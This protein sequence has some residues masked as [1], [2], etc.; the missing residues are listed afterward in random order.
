MQ[1]H[2]LFATAE[3]LVLRVLDSQRRRID[4]FGLFRFVAVHAFDRQTDRIALE[5]CITC[6]CTIKT[7]FITKV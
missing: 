6:S 3:L 7:K 2:G 4:R 5:R 1:S